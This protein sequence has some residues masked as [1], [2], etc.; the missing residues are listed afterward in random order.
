MGS[1]EGVRAPLLINFIVWC[2]GLM[3]YVVDKSTVL[4][5]K[6][7]FDCECEVKDESVS[8]FEQ[9]QRKMEYATIFLK[10]FK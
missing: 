1:G 5:R 8:S 2:E 3:F 6:C 7:G 9:N 10:V 4:L